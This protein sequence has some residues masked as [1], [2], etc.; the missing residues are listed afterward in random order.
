MRAGSLM[1]AVTLIGEEYVS[2]DGVEKYA[3]RVKAEA[4]LLLDSSL[5]PWHIEVDN[6][7]VKVYSRAVQGTEVSQRLGV[8][9]CVS[10]TTG[11]WHTA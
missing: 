1:S 9:L 11:R 2:D 6:G 5:E 10:H 7:Q 8:L 4:R 3:E